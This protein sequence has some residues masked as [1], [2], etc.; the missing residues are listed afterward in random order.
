MRRPRS[1]SRPGRWRRCAPRRTCGSW[2]R[3]SWAARDGITQACRRR[4]RA[5]QESG[6]QRGGRGDA[7]QGH[8]S[9]PTPKL[10]GLE[11]AWRVVK[12]VKSNAIVPRARGRRGGSRRRRG[13]SDVTANR[14]RARPE[15]PRE[16]GPRVGRVLPRSPTRWRLAG[17]EPAVAHP[18]GQR[19]RRRDR[20][21]RRRRRDGHGAHKRSALTSRTASAGPRR[22]K[23]N[24]WRFGSPPVVSGRDVVDDEYAASARSASTSS[25]ATEMK[26]LD[27]GFA[28]S[29]SQDCN[30]HHAGRT[31]G[32]TCSRGRALPVDLVSQVG[33]GPRRVATR[34]LRGVPLA[35]VPS[36]RTPGRAAPAPDTGRPAA[37]RDRRIAGERDGARRAARPR[38]LAVFRQQGWHRGKTTTSVTLAAGMAARGLRVLLVDTDSARQCLGLGVKADKTLP[39]ARHGN[40]RRAIVHVRPN[41]N[42]IASNETL[43]AAE[44]YLAGRQP[45]PCARQ[46]VGFG[47]GGYDV[48]V[49]DCSPSLSLVDREPRFVAVDGVVGPSRPRLSLSGGGGVRAST[50]CSTIGR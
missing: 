20:R 25:S 36:P 46:W 23:P 8:E 35:K 43:A 50:L 6:R 49:L 3:A 18:R 21:G 37:L 11:L 22:G 33:A 9:K 24:T 32:T 10:R 30:V 19:A 31:G 15:T 17:A 7:R 41:L 26:E 44:L 13:R 38:R 39:R 16:D 40:A 48:V 28:F 5:V 27:G 29:A 4:V 14:M 12:H 45:R 47:V 34:L 1:H 42:I 2:R